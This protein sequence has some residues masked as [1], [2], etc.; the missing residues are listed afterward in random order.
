MIGTTFVDAMDITRH[1][2]PIK[3]LGGEYEC[4]VFWHENGRSVAGGR[5][6][7][8][9]RLFASPE[10]NIGFRVWVPE[11]EHDDEDDRDE[12]RFR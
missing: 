10:S 4:E 3:D 5:T 6:K 1:V 11:E 2:R 12:R 8:G 9:K 7:I